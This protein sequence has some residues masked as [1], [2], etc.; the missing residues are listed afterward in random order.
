MSEFSITFLG[1][2][3]S[4]PCCEQKYQKYGGHTS[5]VLMETDEH[6]LFF[7]TGSGIATAN[8]YIKNKAQKEIHL[9]FSHV[10]L[11]H[12]LGFPAYDALWDQNNNIHIYAG[13][14]EP[15]GGI[16][17]FLQKTFTPPLFPIDFKSFPAKITC[18]DFKAGDMLTLSS[19]VNINTC[20]LNHPNGA[21]G[22]R[23][24][25]DG[26]SA[27]YVTDT[28]HKIGEIDQRIATLIHKTDLFIYDSTFTDVSYRQHKGWGHSTWQEG[29]R[30][31]K[32]ANVKNTAIFHHAPE[33]DDVIMDEIDKQIGQMNGNLFIARQGQQIH[34]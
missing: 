5:C 22:Y 14:L 3:G 32:I 28:E 34:L 27:C 26:K 2:R 33:H 21:I 7:D 31:S 9:F 8:S 6:I 11:D 18:Q 19:G 24:N 1:V 16:K 25:Y 17:A 20:A 23:V 13:T 15:Y 30:L 12:I 29:G 4:T 10:H